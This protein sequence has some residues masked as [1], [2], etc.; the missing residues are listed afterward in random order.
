M[1]G[2]A[3]PNALPTEREESKFQSGGANTPGTH[4]GNSEPECPKEESEW[5]AYSQTL[6][7]IFF[8][9]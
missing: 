8:D 2:L 4:D 9:I 6:L 7:K 5:Q 1:S 3:Q